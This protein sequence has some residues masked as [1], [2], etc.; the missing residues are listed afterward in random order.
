MGLKKIIIFGVVDLLAT[1]GATL[2]VNAIKEGKI[3]PKE[4]VKEITDTIK[5]S[6]EKITSVN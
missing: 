5:H 1:A 4:R 6:C 3:K 2:L